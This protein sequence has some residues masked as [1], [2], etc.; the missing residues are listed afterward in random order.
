M[1]RL[2]PRSTLFPYTTLFRS[3]R[4]R[5]CAQRIR[6]LEPPDPAVPRELDAVGRGDVDG[7][8]ARHDP[9]GRDVLPFGPEL[10]EIPVG[11]R[12]TAVGRQPPAVPHRAVPDLAPG[13]ESERVHE[14][15]RDGVGARVARVPDLL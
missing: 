6:D 14:I 8:A 15:P 12:R 4:C 10:R 13:A 9:V 7:V 1:I 5:S 3:M 2:P 11:P